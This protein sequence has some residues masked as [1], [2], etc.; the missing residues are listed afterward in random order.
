MYMNNESKPGPKTEEGKA[1]SSQNA[2]KHGLTAKTISLTNE[3]QAELDA[4]LAEYM[5]DWQPVGRTERDL[6]VTLAS[7]HFR[8][9][10]IRR[11]ETASIDYHSGLML[12]QVQKV[13]N[14]DTPLVQSAG[15][16]SAAKQIDFFGRHEARLDRMAREARKQLIVLQDRR[17]KLSTPEP[18]KKSQNESTKLPALV[19]INDMIRT[20]L[21]PS[22]GPNSEWERGL[23]K[24]HK[25]A[26]TN[27]GTDTQNDPNNTR[28]KEPGDAV[29]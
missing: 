13:D 28:P 19:S 29:A 12:E 8:I 6:V 4:I 24:L 18:A 20:G 10:R 3:D 26:Q 21:C 16:H 15:Y 27:P 14:Y 11:M 2:L 7:C 1:R 17:R 23:R 22:L 9:E 5:D 25:I